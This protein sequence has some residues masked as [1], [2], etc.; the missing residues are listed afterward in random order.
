MRAIIVALAGAYLVTMPAS[1]AEPIATTDGESPG[2][3]LQVKE[4]KVSNGTV[5]LK[6]MIVND[7]AG[8]FGLDDRMADHTVAKVDNAS[9][10]GVYLI[11]AAN[12]K[13]YLVVYDADNHCICSRE[14]NNIAP[15]SSANLWAKFPAPP[16]NV[17]K[18]GVVVPHFVPMDDVPLSR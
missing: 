4:L 1:A 2:T 9:I 17:T 18:I 8:G 7:S 16:D 10:S 3:S 6:F 12:K 14:S 15:K 5:M 11:D 13:K